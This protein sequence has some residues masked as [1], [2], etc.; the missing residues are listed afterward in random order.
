[1]HKARSDWV[2][3]P[4]CGA[5][6]AALVDGWASAA[7]EMAPG[8]AAAIAAWRRRRHAHLAAGAS[9]LRVGHVDLAGEPPPQ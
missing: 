9:R 5:L 2:L 3:G 6:Q 4:G 7:R 1:M 8:E